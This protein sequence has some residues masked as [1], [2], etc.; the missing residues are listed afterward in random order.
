[1]CKYYIMSSVVFISSVD[2]LT[3]DSWN[4][5]YFFDW[6]Q[7]EDCEYDLYVGGQTNLMAA[8]T[9]AAMF[10]SNLIGD[11]MPKTAATPQNLL[12][13]LFLHEYLKNI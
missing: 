9:E 8:S 4:A 6:T 11:Y 5:D 3:G 13:N 10:T 12:C 7:L 2:K 1:M